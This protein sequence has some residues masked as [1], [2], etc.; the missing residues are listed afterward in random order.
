MKS[1]PAQLYSKTAHRS[2][3]KKTK[4]KTKNTKRILI[5][6]LHCNIDNLPIGCF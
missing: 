4:T 5:C 2:L 3:K 1:N 6:I